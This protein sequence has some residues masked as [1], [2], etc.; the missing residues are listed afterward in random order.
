MSSRLVLLTLLAS[1]LLWLPG[2]SSIEIASERSPAHDFGRLTSWAWATDSPEY[3][4]T[5][6]RSPVS[7]RSP[8]LDDHVRA[9]I[10]SELATRGFVKVAPEQA[11]FLVGYA[12][13][14]DRAD[15]TSFGDFLRYKSLGGRGNISE[16]YTAGFSEGSIAIDA[17]DRST[18][19]LIWRGSA[20]AVFDPDG[21]G[22]RIAPAV[23]QIF[24]SFPR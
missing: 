19:E 22:D 14:L 21:K 24:D 20:S 6:V 9:A 15:V 3:V 7:R 11:D 18:A 1:A 13:L 17:Y 2:C 10:E 4:G 12:L 23:Q 16:S 8:F 5:K